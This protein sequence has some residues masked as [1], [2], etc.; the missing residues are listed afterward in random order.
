MSGSNELAA[1][2]VMVDLESSRP[3]RRALAARLVRCGER[4]DWW[5]IALAFAPLGWK[6]DGTHSSRIE[7]AP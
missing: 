5:W 6:L 3:A 1:R 7:A 2:A 4:G